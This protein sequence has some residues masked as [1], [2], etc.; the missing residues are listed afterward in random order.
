MDDS[1]AFLLTSFFEG[2]PTSVL[3]CCARG[4]PIVTSNVGGMK[5]I[6]KEKEN[7]FVIDSYDKFKFKKAI[8]EIYNNP[9]LS[10]IMSKNNTILGAEF[11]WDKVANN[12]TQKIKMKLNTK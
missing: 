6:I 1:F 7:G 4:L 12:I 8:D 10:K 2:T 11:I 9:D 5:S 3:E